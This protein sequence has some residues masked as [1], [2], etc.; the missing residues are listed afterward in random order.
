MRVAKA[1]TKGYTDTQVRLSNINQSASSD[2][3]D[4]SQGCDLERSMGSLGY[5]DERSRP[6]DV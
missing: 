1:Y 3:I 6:N 5:S 2:D 4:K